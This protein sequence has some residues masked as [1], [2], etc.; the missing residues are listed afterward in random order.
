MRLRAVGAQESSSTTPSAAYQSP[1]QHATLPTDLS[2]RQLPLPCHPPT[3]RPSTTLAVTRL[4]RPSTLSQPPALAQPPSHPPY[5]PEPEPHCLARA[6]PVVGCKQLDDATVRPVGLPQ[7]GSR[8]CEERRGVRGR[9]VAAAWHRAAV[10][11]LVS[12]QARARGARGGRQAA[13]KPVRL[14]SSTGSHARAGTSTNAGAGASSLPHPPPRHGKGYQGQ[15]DRPAGARCCCLKRLLRCCMA[16]LPAL[17]AA[18]AAAAP[19]AAA[20]A[21]GRR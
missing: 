14:R 13:G 11:R 4:S 7:R 16:L 5:Q 9:P 15:R 17:S 10:A 12:V 3:N 18:A 6:L 1:R 8:Q 20:A 21:A 19:A 2:L